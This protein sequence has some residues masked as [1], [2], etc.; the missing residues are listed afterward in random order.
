MAGPQ[1]YRL[2][3]Q[4]PYDPNRG[5][6]YGTEALQTMRAVTLDEYFTDDVGATCSRAILCTVDG[7]ITL[8]WA[9]QTTTTIPIIAGLLTP[10]RAF[11]VH[12][13]GTTA[14]GL[15]WGY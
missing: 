9:D 15:F 5:L 1:Q 12:T 2:G 14:T 10:Y 6:P 4:T 11:R 7:N 3:A 13:S 8:E